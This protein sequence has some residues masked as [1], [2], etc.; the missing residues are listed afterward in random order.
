VLSALSAVA[1][2]S[3]TMNRLSLIAAMLLLV[4][5]CRASARVGGPEPSANGRATLAQV[6]YW[7]AKP[8]MLAQY[9]KYILEVA[10]PID[11]IAQRD[12]A[13]VTVTTYMSGDTLSP[14]THMRVFMLRDSAQLAGLSAALDAAGRKFEPDSTKRRM[15]GEYAVTLRDRV[16][17]ALLQIVH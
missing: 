17:G 10:E 2:G 15:R 9:N 12:G 6:Y 3:Q 11:A 14:W 7:K 1:L 8:G 16:G 5:G 4:A 13:F